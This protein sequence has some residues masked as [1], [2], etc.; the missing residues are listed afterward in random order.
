MAKKRDEKVKEPETDPITRLREAARNDMVTLRNQLLVRLKFLRQLVGTNYAQNGAQNAVMLPMLELMTSIYT[1]N[2]C[3]KDPRSLI[4]T[5]Y[6]ELRPEADTRTKVVNQIAQ[7]IGLSTVFENGFRES[8][9][10]FGVFKVGMNA[11]P[12]DEV[13]NAKVYGSDFFV[14]HIQ[15][16]DF[17]WDMGADDITQS[18]YVMHR[19]RVPKQWALDSGLYDKEVIENAPTVPRLWQTNSIDRANQIFADGRVFDQDY[20][21][22]IDLW[23]VYRQFENRLTTFVGNNSSTEEFLG[24]VARD[25][26]F[27]GPR[28][29]PYVY[30]KYTKVPGN[31]MPLSPVAVV[32]DLHMAIN[33]NYRKL[34]RQSRRSKSI[35]T[36]LAGATNDAQALTNANDGEVHNVNGGAIAEFKFGAV[37]QQ[38]YA[39]LIDQ[40]QRFSTMCGNLDLLGGLA[41][42]SDT[43]GQDKIL[44]A[45]ASQRI[46]WMKAQIRG[47]LTQIFQKLLE[48]VD[49]DQTN[50]YRVM[51]D[52]PGGIQ[53]PAFLT[54][55]N[56][57]GNLTQFNCTVNPYSLQDDTPE[58]RAGKMLKLVEVAA[59][60]QAQMAE[61]GVVLNWPF[62][63]KTVGKYLN[64][65]ETNGMFQFA[66]PPK[67]RPSEASGAAQPRNPS[68]GKPK[69]YTHQNVSRETSGSKDAANLQ[70]MQAMAKN[71]A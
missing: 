34:Q 14:S 7:Q 62:I 46:L 24:E 59:P 65:D 35:G 61:Q 27:V 40:I 31:S 43:L 50:S 2:L 70:A 71:A 4:T 6:P 36:V 9:F 3:P 44:S 42:Q 66:D 16:E 63:I 49:A 1:Q 17:I 33:E 47:A 10:S 11:S 39:L 22:Y 45:G 26:D 15:P 32:Y 18:S 8:L 58:T 68:S 23:E 5:E 21:E 12:M 20:Y 38:V 13:E 54:P 67:E 41:P 56:K 51:K 28:G 57:K 69:V 19:S 29:G 37:D 52:A 53:I 25:V 30:L 55:D 60:N 48:Y 64:I